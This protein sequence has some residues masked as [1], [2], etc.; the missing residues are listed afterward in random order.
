MADEP[1]PGAGLVTA[2]KDGNKPN[3][4][5]APV[6][7]FEAGHRF[8]EDI[9]GLVVIDRRDL[10][11]KDIVTPL[12]LANA[13]AAI[14]NG[15]TLWQPRIVTAAT[16]PDGTVVATVEPWTRRK[17]TSPAPPSKTSS[18]SPP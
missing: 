3:E 7:D 6:A 11:D 1:R 5:Q 12:Q 10:A 2:C 13:Y 15:G 17:R 9:V 4:N 18:S 16:L 14:G 8:G